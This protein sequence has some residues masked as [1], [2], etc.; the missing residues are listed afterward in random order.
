MDKEL[1]LK[2]AREA[3]KLSYSPYSHFA[4]GACV[5]LKDGTYIQ[6]AN[7]E[8]SSYGLSLCAERNAIFQAVLK[9]YRKKEDFVA[10]AIACDSPSLPYPC[11]ACRQV[12][13]EFF[14]MKTPILITNF[15]NQVLEK[16]LEE[17]MPY[18]FVAENLI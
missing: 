1:L 18:A 13:G 15:N 2:K 3:C 6:G 5:L 17:L 8:N 9:G 12:M 4:V 16:T 10:L 11:G 14:D 7:I